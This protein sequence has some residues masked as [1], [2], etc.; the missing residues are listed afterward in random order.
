M[1]QFP[2]GLDGEQMR[3]LFGMLYQKTILDQYKKENQRT[4]LEARASYLFAAPYNAAL[5]TDMYDHASF[6]RMIVN[7]GFS[8]LNWSPK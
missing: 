2:S 5:Y 3:Q 7:S 8:G 6:V 4:M 1:A